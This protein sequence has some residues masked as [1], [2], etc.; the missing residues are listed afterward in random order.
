[1]SGSASPRTEKLSESRKNKDATA[2]WGGTAG[3]VEGDKWVVE[4]VLDK[5][6]R[7]GITEYE[8]KWEGWPDADITGE[9]RWTT[10]EDGILD[11]L[12]EEFEANKPPKFCAPYTLGSASPIDPGVAAHLVVDWVTAIGRRCAAMLARQQEEWAVKKV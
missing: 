10:N 7:Q 2:E 8:V 9:A 3:H 4:K 5:R 6:T 12:I 1:M 11:E